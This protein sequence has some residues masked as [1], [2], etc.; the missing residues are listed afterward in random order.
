MLKGP[1]LRLTCGSVSYKVRNLN[2]LYSKTVKVKYSKV[3]ISDKN[4][5]CIFIDV[6]FIAM[7]FNDLVCI[8]S[9]LYVHVSM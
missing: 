6:Q 8:H 9:L 1:I 7:S 5:N 3:N 4:R 2:Y